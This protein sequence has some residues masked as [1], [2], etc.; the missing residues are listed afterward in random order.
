MSSTTAMDQLFNRV[1][2]TTGMRLKDNELW[3]W[4]SLHE[5]DVERAARAVERQFLL[6]P[7]GAR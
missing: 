4:L 7:V 2:E 6:Q 5:E 1:V 3:H